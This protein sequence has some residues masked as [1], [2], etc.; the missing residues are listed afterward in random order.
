MQ[1]RPCFAHLV[2]LA[3]AMRASA[4]A[5]ASRPV[6]WGPWCPT[7]GPCRPASA[8]LVADRAVRNR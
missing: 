2:R 8:S 4:G 7:V 3:T 6:G 5:V 1:P